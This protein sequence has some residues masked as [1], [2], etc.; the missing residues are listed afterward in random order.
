MPTLEAMNTR[1][2][3]H[4]GTTDLQFKRILVAIDFSK[5]TP[6]VLSTAIQIANIFES[7][8]F[9]V[10]AAAL[11]V[12]GTGAEPVPLETFDVNLRIAQAC[13]AELVEAEPALVNLT[14]KEIVA[15]ATPLDLVRQVIADSN[16]DLVITGSHGKSG[17]EHLMLGS[18]AECIL[19]TVRCP[20][21]VIGSKVALQTVGFSSILLAAALTATGSQSAQCAAAFAE[22]FHSRLTL[23]HV[24]EPKMARTVQPELLEDRLL[25]KLQELIPAGSPVRATVSSRVE[26][27]KAGDVIASVALYKRAD[28]VV[29]GAGEERPLSDRTPWSTLAEVIRRVRCPVLCVRGH[30]G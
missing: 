14:H 18:V 3:S 27:G 10:H 6:Q 30:S 5:R 22:H 26:Y 15:Y 9:L 24:V 28:L 1:R 16:I 25:A 19:R 4:P 21:M 8:L 7:E 29:M 23:L 2:A 12:Y 11:A 13:M 17:I 20:V